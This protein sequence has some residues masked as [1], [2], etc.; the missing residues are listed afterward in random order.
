[1]FDKYFDDWEVK[2]QFKR[3]YVSLWPSWLGKENIHMLDQ[4]TKEEWSR[5]NSFILAISQIYKLGLVDCNAGSVTFPV[6]IESTLSDYSGSMN[7]DSSV[8]SKYVIP[9]LDCVLTEEWDYT[10]IIW[11]KHNSAVDAL[12]PYILASK[13]QHFST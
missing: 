8:F 10:Y 3:E 4:V 5:F 12:I 11:H 1:M 9:E 2:P 13:L 6:N 7:K